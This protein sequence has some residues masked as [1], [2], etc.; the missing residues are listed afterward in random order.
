MHK[1]NL[2]MKN[3]VILL[4]FLNI[5]LSY[6]QNIELK[7]KTWWVSLKKAKND[8]EIGEFY[9]MFPDSSNRKS[10]DNS[11]YIEEN[12]YFYD[13]N[14]FYYTLKGSYINPYKKEPHL[15]YSNSGKW[16][17]KN[18]NVVEISIE[19]GEYNRSIYTYKINI[20]E[21]FETKVILTLIDFN[22]VTRDK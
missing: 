11:M 5:Q 14:E 21:K 6:S 1:I 9:E 18:S 2:K 19:D 17:L 12:L 7:D 4:F 3:I 8:I 16:E 10:I 13:N 20:S 15:Q 22:F